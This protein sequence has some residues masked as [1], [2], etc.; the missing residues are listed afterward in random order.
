VNSAGTSGSSFVVDCDVHVAAPSVQ[1]LDPYLT[2]YWRNG[3]REA[4]IRQ[5]QAIEYTFPDWS[6]QA[7]QPSD[8]TPDEIAA[9][10]LGLADLAILNCCYGLE[11]LRHPYLAPALATAVN[12]W[13]RE[14]W[15]A[16][17][18]RF[19]ASLVVAVDDADPAV[20]EIRR[21]G[22]DP[23]FVQVLVA[24]RSWEPLGRRRYWPIW[25][26]AA[27]HGL[28]VGI[29]VGGL[30]GPDPT[31]VGAYDSFFE[32]YVGGYSVLQTQLVSFIAEGVLAAYPDLRLCLLEGGVTWLPTLLWKLD[33]E[34]KGLR[35]EI[36]WVRRRPSEYVRDQVRM[37]AQPLDAPDDPNVLREVLEHLGT[38]TML[39]YASDYP[40]DHG[41]SPD[42]LLAVLSR[43][44]ADRL[45]G[46]NAQECYRLD[47]RL[48]PWFSAVR[49]SPAE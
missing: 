46:S 16:R 44:Q 42:R 36:P 22:S 14:E 8:T 45:L 1:A 43:A 13:L 2:E 19:L 11:A 12:S 9:K 3:L 48:G 4:G 39:L 6:T 26:A 30:A 41:P 15:L 37:S 33:T 20:A 27:E 38:D 25:E 32:E 40:H 18:E 35:R 31:P 21:V 34:W 7:I 23:R 29:H 28:A 10:V 49:P 17:D 24:A 5:P 47:Q